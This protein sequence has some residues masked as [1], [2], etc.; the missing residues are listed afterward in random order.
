LDRNAS[1]SSKDLLFYF[2]TTNTN[3]D[4]I[5][6]S[7]IEFLDADRSS[8]NWEGPTRINLHTETYYDK[9]ITFINKKNE[10]PVFKLTVGNPSDKG[11][12]GILKI[13]FTADRT[14]PGNYKL[15]IWDNTENDTLEFKFKII[16]EDIPYTLRNPK[17]A[18]DIMYYVLTD[19][20]YDE[21]KSGSDRE[22]LHKIFEWWRKHDP[23]RFT[24]YN[25]AMAEYFNRADYAFFNF[26]T[27]YEKD[28]AKTDRGKIY[29]L[30][31]APDD[32]KNTM[33][34]KGE[35]QEIWIYHKLKKQFTFE[36][37]KTD[38]IYLKEI[39]DL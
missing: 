21:I 24:L 17:Y 13:T 32:V 39:K 12:G 14:A 11:Y 4:K 9:V 23:T 10:R 31:G 25:E 30:Y 20:E 37:D 26:K 34:E 5:Y 36:T 27:I 6:S 19:E 38:I 1:F 33:N 18:A 2:L 8:I 35:A 3:P 15:R 28:G 22:I 7:S 29:I 16:W